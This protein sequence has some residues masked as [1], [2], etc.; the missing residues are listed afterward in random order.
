MEVILAFIFLVILFVIW[1]LFYCFIVLLFLAVGVLFPLISI[2]TLIW[3]WAIL[4]ILLLRRFE[5]AR[6]RTQ[7]LVVLEKVRLGENRKVAHVFHVGPQVPISQNL[8]L[9]KALRLQLLQ[10]NPNMQLHHYLN[11]NPVWG[12][13][14]KGIPREKVIESWKRLAEGK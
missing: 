10:A 3:T 1:T 7:L 8:G 5:F 13:F 2:Y 4:A 12:L 6:S 9:C 11:A 14:E